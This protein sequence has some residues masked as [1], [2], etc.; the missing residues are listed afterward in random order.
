MCERQGKSWSVGDAVTITGAG[1]RGRISALGFAL[2]SR[3]YSPSLPFYPI[4]TKLGYLCC[5]ARVCFSSRALFLP[6]YGMG[7]LGNRDYSIAQSLSGDAGSE[8]C[9]RNKEEILAESKRRNEVGK[10]LCQT[11]ALQLGATRVGQ[12]GVWMCCSGT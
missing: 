8:T 1:A 5:V 11:F 4:Q 7:G 12:R 6:K 9:L 3:S 10:G 2:P